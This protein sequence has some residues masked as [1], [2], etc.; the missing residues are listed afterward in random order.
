MARVLVTGAAGFI[1]RRLSA[2]LLD[3]GHAVIGVDS[4][5]RGQ[6]HPESPFVVRDLARDDLADLIAQVDVVAHHA[7]RPGVRESWGPSFDGYVRDNV[8]ATQRLME[9][10]RGTA[11]S[12][13]IVASSSAVYG[14]A[15]AYPTAENSATSPVSPYGVTKL[16][17]ERLAIAYAT[18]FGLPVVCLRYF[19]VFGPGQ[20]PDMAFSRLITAA[21]SGAPFPLYGDGEQ[22]RDFTYVDDIAAANLAVI[23]SRIAPGSVFNVAGGATATLNDAIA[24]VERL[25]GRSIVVDRRPAATGDAYRTGADTTALRNATGWRPRVGLEEGLMA[26]LASHPHGMSRN[27]PATVAAAATAPDPDPA[28]IA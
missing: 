2:V 13:V 12:R 11:L 4:R 10:C 7:G 28:R 25:T 5:P 26:Q 18:S 20:R 6:S 23:D 24:T 16:A 9:A 22:V 17:A 21:G 14:D 19:T 15:L 8:V 3:A 27:E 1:G